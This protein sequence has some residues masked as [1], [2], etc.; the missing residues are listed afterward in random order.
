MIFINYLS[1]KTPEDLL[2]KYRV[3]HRLF[4]T[5][6]MMT[7]PGSI[8]GIIYGEKGSGRFIEALSR[9]LDQK[10]KMADR[11]ESIYYVDSDCFLYRPIDDILE[12][13][14]DVAVTYRY[15]WEEHG[16]RQDCLGGFLWF[17][18][19]RPDVEDEFLETLIAATKKRYNDEV[20]RKV[21]PWYYDQLA[22]NDVVGDSPV[23]RTHED[24]NAGKDFEPQIKLVDGVR[25][26][27]LS[28]NIFAS[29]MTIIPRDDVRMVHYN[30]AYWPE[31]A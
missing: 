28:A 4:A 17:S 13:D 27:F 22:I 10:K 3:Q 15:K 12:L 25:V 6:V 20:K 18:G 21:V 16:G 24:Y 11:N 31:G 19:R 30:H 26:L 14:F 1:K 2:R 29:P 8:V 23:S 5:S 7:M 9:L